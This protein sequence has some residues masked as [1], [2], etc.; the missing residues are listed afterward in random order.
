MGEQLI[1][2]SWYDELVGSSTNQENV[3]GT[4]CYGYL[5]MYPTYNESI[6]STNKS[7]CGDPWLK[8]TKEY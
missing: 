1:R 3:F 7:V 8:V 2:S 4:K 5:I 6:E